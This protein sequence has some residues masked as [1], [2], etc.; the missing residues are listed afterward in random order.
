MKISISGIRGVYGVD[1]FPE[2]VLKF[3]DGFSKLIKNGKCVIGR[4]TRE[5]GEMIE[6]LVSARL[7]ER[8]IEVHHLGITPTPVV[9]RKAK[10]IGA[11]IIITSSHNPLDWNGLKFIIDGR[12]ITLD[13]LEIVKNG[14]NS[15]ENKIGREFISESNYISDAVNIIGKLNKTQQVTVDIGGGAAKKVAP[16]LL[17]E[18]GCKK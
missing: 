13:E 9:F 18:I 8:G 2:D 6:K 14:K 12:G 4:D 17:Q 15:N 16:K 7:L 5:T 10:E 3:C 1:F 11:G